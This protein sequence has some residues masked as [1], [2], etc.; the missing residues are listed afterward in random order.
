MKKWIMSIIFFMTLFMA[1]GCETSQTPMSVHSVAI[2]DTTVAYDDF[3]LENINLYVTYRDF[4]TERV[5]LNQSMFD[6]EDLE[7]IDGPGRYVLDGVYRDYPFSFTL[8]LT[9]ALDE[10]LE[11][12]AFDDKTLTDDVDLSVDVNAGI[13]VNWTAENPEHLNASGIVTRPLY[14]DVSA[15]LTLTL[16][17][18][19][20][21][22]TRSF[23]FTVK[24]MPAASDFANLFETNTTGDMVVVD[25]VVTSVYDGGIIL[26]DGAMHLFVDI[27]NTE[28]MT[29]G[30]R[31]VIEG[32]LGETN[33][34]TDVS[35]HVVA[36][37][38]V[39]PGDTIETVDLDVLLAL[40]ASNLGHVFNVVGTVVER[41]D[42]SF[43]IEA[44]DTAVPIDERTAALRRIELAEHVGQLV[45]IRVLYLD[46]EDPTFVYDGALRALQPDSSFMGHDVDATE[47]FVP[48]LNLP[49]DGPRFDEA[50][51][52][53]TAYEAGHNGYMG[54]G[55]AYH[56]TYNRC[57]DGDTTVFNYPADIVSR[58]AANNNSTRYFLMDT[59]ETWP[60]DRQEP[61]G[62][63]A[64]VFVCHLLNEAESI[65]LQSD[66]GDRFLDVHGRL[67]AWVWIRMPGDDDYMLL[68][69]L[70]VRHGLGDVRYTFGAGETDLITDQGMRLLDW[71]NLAEDR[72]FIDELGMWGELPDFYYDY[73]NNR[74]DDALYPH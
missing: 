30:D 46:H 60:V 49:Y 15:T 48:N 73:E 54:T 64:T 68:N 69:Y 61:F 36:D 22:L 72:A 18:G 26:F 44:D 28:T 4:S 71:M 59:P 42:G 7:A 70:V 9:D 6:S 19:S 38:R 63:L 20:R 39:E 40:D 52:G 34:L 10:A 45:S 57:I 47:F 27:D 74:I 29:R 33:Q 55:G 67:L 23:T 5:P 24:A 12:I 2:M 14:Q 43:A 11:N 16:D 65:I 35:R 50:W 1:A 25:G 17:D 8:T 66:P 56:V 58:I 37:T 51:L 62:A 53:V 32:K 41:G 31:L 13:D 21:T 3:S